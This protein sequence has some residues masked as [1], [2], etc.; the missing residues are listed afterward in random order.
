MLCGYLAT[1]LN[2]AI[3]YCVLALQPG[4]HQVTPTATRQQPDTAQNTA[5]SHQA[6]AWLL[7]SGLHSY[8]NGTGSQVMS[9]SVAAADDNTDTSVYTSAPIHSTAS[10][11][12]LADAAHNDTQGPAEGVSG[13]PQLD[14]CMS[15]HLAASTPKADLPLPAKAS[16][17]HLSEPV[18][19]AASTAGTAQLDLDVPSQ[20]A[21]PESQEG[22]QAV[23]PAVVRGRMV[24]SELHSRQK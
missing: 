8:Q 9:P 14:L 18:G 7:T 16:Q 13:T 15:T 3:I 12:D 19:G 22:D 10:G 2:D 24:R 11:G 21:E 5:H 6:P 17:H 20:L 23:A 4:H 1:A